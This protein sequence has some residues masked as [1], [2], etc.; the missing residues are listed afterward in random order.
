MNQILVIIRSNHEGILIFSKHNTHQQL[1]AN[2]LAHNHGDIIEPPIPDIDKRI[3]WD[4]G[5]YGLLT[6]TYY[7]IN[8]PGMR[9]NLGQ[10]VALFAVQNPHD[11]IGL[12]SD[13]EVAFSLL[14]GHQ[15]DAGD[16][17]LLDAFVRFFQL[18]LSIVFQVEE[19]EV[20]VACAHEQ[21]ARIFVT[22]DTHD[23]L[24]FV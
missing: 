10:K 20:T 6:M 12:P 4:C 22:T 7:G 2:P 1:V 3:I 15:F 17:G 13:E 9:L 21:I 5:E 23:G 11:P 24:R 8:C 18:H 14:I 16:I 19:I